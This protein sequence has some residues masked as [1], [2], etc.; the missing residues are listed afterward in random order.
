[1]IIDVLNHNPSCWKK[2]RNNMILQLCDFWRKIIQKKIWSK[3]HLNWQK[4]S[5]AVIR[6]TPP[7]HM[8]CFSSQGLTQALDVAQ[9]CCYT[10]PG[11]NLWH[12]WFCCHLEL[13]VIPW[14][15]STASPACHLLGFLR[16]MA[17]VQKRNCFPS[18]LLSHPDIIAT[19][20]MPHRPLES[21]SCG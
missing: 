3:S 13:E 20:K 16:L 18:D 6:E 7:G 2:K 11:G 14:V 21:I 12:Y 1:M 10:S 19:P 8:T 9:W 4:L 17:G 15:F 5:V